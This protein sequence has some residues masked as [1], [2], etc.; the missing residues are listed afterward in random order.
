MRRLNVFVNGISQTS[1]GM[2]GT[3]SGMSGTVDTSVK[4]S[5][6]ISGTMIGSEDG[7]A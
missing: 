3:T 4:S 1:S 2:S 7:L 6:G 5:S